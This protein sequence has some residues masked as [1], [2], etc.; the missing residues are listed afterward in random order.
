MTVADELEVVIDDLAPAYQEA[1]REL[2]AEI[3]NRPEEDQ[4]VALRELIADRI[5]A[6]DLE[7]DDQ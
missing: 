3:Q 7:D 4:L 2:V 1:A 6:L 5:R